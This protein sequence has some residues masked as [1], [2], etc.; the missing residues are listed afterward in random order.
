MVPVK[1]TWPDWLDDAKLTGEEVGVYEHDSDAA[2]GNKGI[3]HSTLFFLASF[4]GGTLRFLKVVN[5]D[6]QQRN[7]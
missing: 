2:S 3:S 7:I 6:S 1:D 5:A 4:Y